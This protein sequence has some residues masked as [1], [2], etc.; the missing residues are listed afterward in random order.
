MSID[1]RIQWQTIL[2]ASCLA[3]S[4]YTLSAPCASAAN[5]KSAKDC[6]D[7]LRERNAELAAEKI[8]I[9]VFIQ[10]CWKTSRGT[11]TPMEPM[12]AAQAH[13]V[14]L[15]SED[16]PRSRPSNGPARQE[17]RLEHVL[18]RTNAVLRHS[19]SSY[20]GDAGRYKLVERRRSKTLARM[21]PAP[22]KL[23]KNGHV[24]RPQTAVVVWA[25][26]ELGTIWESGSP[27]PACPRSVQQA[28][29]ERPR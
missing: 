11:Q 19:K 8:S 13:S 20:L 25:A 17:A 4:L 21:L 27:H 18:K 26:S 5:V 10:E 16:K 7:E 3:A 14:P 24:L 23:A 29:L 1:M 22:R 6:N 12:K 28:L 15:I 9:R 2:V